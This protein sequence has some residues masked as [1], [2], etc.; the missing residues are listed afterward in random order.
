VRRVYGTPLAEG[1]ESMAAPR[2]KEE[3]AV[4]VENGAASVDVRRPGE[5]RESHDFVEGHLQDSCAVSH[6]EPVASP[7]MVALGV[8]HG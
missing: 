6:S 4:P 1:E 2:S 7:R 8:A 3:S 5:K